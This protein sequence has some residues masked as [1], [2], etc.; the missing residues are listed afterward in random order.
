[1]TAFEIFTPYQLSL[2]VDISSAAY[3]VAEIRVLVACKRFFQTFCKFL[4]M[5]K[6]ASD[7]VEQGFVACLERQAY[8][9]QRTRRAG[10]KA[11]DK[12]RHDRD[13]SQSSTDFDEQRE[14]RQMRPG[15]RKPNDFECDSLRAEKPSV[16]SEQ[17]QHRDGLT[18]EQNI[19]EIDAILGEIVARK[20]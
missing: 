16:S 2:D 3:Q 14:G 4:D 11:G 7:H 13:D 18:A 20:P 10:G 17:H 19:A 12:S 6:A 8:K 1:M 5:I 15:R 9:Y